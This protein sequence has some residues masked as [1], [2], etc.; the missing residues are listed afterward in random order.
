MTTTKVKTYKSRSQNLIFEKIEDFAQLVKL[1][2][3]LVVVITSVLAY[4]IVA[5]DHLTL[6]AMTILA[7]GGFFV[8]SAANALNQVLEKDYDA[9]MTRT[10]ERPIVKGRIAIS[11]AVLIAGIC[12]LIGITLLA[13]F[14]PLTA[15]LGTLAMVI[16]AFI[17]TIN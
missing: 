15:L 14:N 3:S 8:T 17:Y 1:K 9:L 16:Y 11:A 12:S 6:G 4:A 10:A 2:L 13:L 7:L 5:W